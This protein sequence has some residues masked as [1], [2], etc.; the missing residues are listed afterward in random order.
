MRKVIAGLGRTEDV[1][2]SPSNCRLAVACF[3]K[4]QIAIFDI[5]ISGAP[6]ERK[7]TLTDAA[8]ISSPYLKC[9][10]G[11]DFLD[12]E[13]IIVANREGDATIFELPRGEGAA[14]AINWIRL[15][16]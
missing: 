2:F 15:A 10:H 3:E 6:Y 9:P 12:E 14:I 8:E 7:I 13:R 4:N 11:I 1:K 5:C 16:S